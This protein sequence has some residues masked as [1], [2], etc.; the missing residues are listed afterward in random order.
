MLS[1]TF[2]PISLYV[3]IELVKLW[4]AYFISEDVE[5]FSEVRD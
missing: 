4:Q 5:M 2:I 1:S 3:T